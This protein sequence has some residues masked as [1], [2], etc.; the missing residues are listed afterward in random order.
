MELE[1]F[2]L[3]NGDFWQLQW[4]CLLEPPFFILLKNKYVV[5]PEGRPIGGLPSKNEASDFEEGESQKAVFSQMALS[6]RCMYVFVVLG[7]VIHFV[8]GSEM[9]IYSIIYASGIDIG[10]INYFRFFI[11]KSR[12]R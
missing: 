1:I 4:Q 12:K 10:R 9:L 7:A 6:L 8:F 11:D 3:L 2:M 5:T